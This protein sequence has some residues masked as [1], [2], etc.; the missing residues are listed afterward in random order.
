MGRGEIKGV[1]AGK[2]AQLHEALNG[3][4]PES[5]LIGIKDLRDPPK[6]L[7]GRGGD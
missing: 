3:E 6:E 2:T 5:D 1:K 7:R 4:V